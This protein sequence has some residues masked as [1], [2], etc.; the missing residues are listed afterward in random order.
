MKKAILLLALGALALNAPAMATECDGY[1]CLSEKIKESCTLEQANGCIDWENGILYAVGMGVPNESL[2]SN[3]QKRY[4]ALEAAKV[5]AM[6]NLLAL[7][8]DVQIS[9]SQTVKMGMLENDT[10]QTEIHGTL[11]HVTQTGQP[12]LASDGTAWVTVKMYLKDLRNILVKNEGFEAVGG[13]APDS[14]APKHSTTAKVKEVAPPK[15]DEVNYGGDVSTVYSGLILDARG[16]G[17]TPA[18][19]PKVLSETGEEVYGSFLVTREFVLDK[20]VAAYLKDMDKALSHERVSGRP[21]VL[22]ATKAEG[23]KGADLSISGADADLLKELTK[24]Q[25]FLQEARVIILL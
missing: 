16:S 7:V 8:E 12:R 21:L 18:M 14:E 20:G 19:S 24:K 23:N 15:A 11:R 17:V 9:S 4:S 3:A 2:K 10:I 25:T 6:R 5:V 13:L 22:K 1:G